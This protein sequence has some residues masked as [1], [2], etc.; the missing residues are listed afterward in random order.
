M[1]IF[2]VWFMVICCGIA[3]GLLYAELETPKNF[4]FI[5]LVSV[6]CIVFLLYHRRITKDWRLSSHETPR[7]WAE[8]HFPCFRV[9]MYLSLFFLVLLIF[10]YQC[11]EAQVVAFITILIASFVAYRRE[12]NYTDGWRWERTDIS[13]DSLINEEN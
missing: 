9:T 12:L 7:T 3:N 4:I 1:K 5:S 6:L 2:F 13:I 11:Y 10:R 8:F